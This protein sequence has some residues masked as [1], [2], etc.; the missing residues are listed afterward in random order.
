MGL[1]LVAAIACAGATDKDT[2]DTT[3]VTDVT[4]DN[5]DT[6]HESCAPGT[7]GGEGSRMLPGSDCLSCHK[8]GGAR[9]AEPWS[10]GGTVFLDAD[11][12]DAGEGAIIRITGA[13]DRVTELTAN[14]VG[15][16]YA[17]RNI[18]FP[19]DVEVEYNGATIQMG[20]QIETGACNSC[21]KCDGEANGKL[22]T[23]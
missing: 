22:Y 21:H 11:G 15:N 5:C 8:S 2:T 13:D 1:A 16:F 20:S 3:D 14:S 23:P 18:A 12:L 7:C 9:E 10:V 17:E 4:P 6:T 19:A